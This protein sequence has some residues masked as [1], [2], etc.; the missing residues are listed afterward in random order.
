MNFL[1]A[2]FFLL[3]FLLTGNSYW[4]AHC[5]SWAGIAYQARARGDTRGRL[6]RCWCN[7]QRLCLARE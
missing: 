5:T 6:G 4:R 7:S 3:L 2:K 1:F